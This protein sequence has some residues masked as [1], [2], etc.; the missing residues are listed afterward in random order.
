MLSDAEPFLPVKEEVVDSSENLAEAKQTTRR[1]SYKKEL[2]L[3]LIIII[4]YT[5]I[6]LA[7]TYFKTQ[8]I[9]VPTGQFGPDSLF[10]QCLQILAPI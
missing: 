2:L 4:L 1:R 8:S 3:H 9:P 6:S 5:A 7:M 10:V